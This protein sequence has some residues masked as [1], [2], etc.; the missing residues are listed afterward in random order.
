MTSSRNLK[1][2]TRTLLAV[3]LAVLTIFPF[4]WIFN[5]AIT[6]SAVLYQGGQTLLPDFT[7]TLNAFQIL[8]TD[9]PFFR[10]MANSTVVALGTTVA[11]VFM[12][13]LAAYALSRYRFHGRGIMGFGLFASQ[14]LPE[15]LIVVPMY[16]LFAALGLLNELHGLVLANTAFIMP[17]AVWILKTAIDGVPYEVE[18]SARVDGCNA[19][20][21]LQFI[22]VPL[23]MPSLAAAAVVA[24]FDGW[25]EYL[26]ATTFI[27][28]SDLWLASTGLASFRGEFSTPL[29]V[30]FSGAFVYA[31]PAIIFFLLL[32]RR[33]V[34]GLTAG[35][36]KG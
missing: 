18:E 17:V 32:Q 20:V 34:S 7:R 3:A 33:I 10:W 5:T 30:V 9:S 21:I 4:Y 27:R 22:V 14:M 31:L 11:S 23:I 25:N 6:P 12:A 1:V 8:T 36:V 24:F 29:D 16:T 28:D 15:A 19:P 2:A 13:T 35:S 26:F